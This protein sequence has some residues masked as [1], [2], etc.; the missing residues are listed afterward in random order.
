[1]EKTFAITVARQYGSGG[2][3][4]GTR[5]A[6]L[7][8]V[9]AY[10]KEL[11]T[12]A[13]QKS[14]VSSEVLG[15]ADERAT[16]SLLYTLALGSSFYTPTA[17]HMNVPIND[18]LFLVQSE[19]IRETAAMESCV[20]I[21]RCADY[22]LRA[23]ENKLRVFVYAQNADRYARLM[24]RNPDKCKNEREAR[25]L[26]QRTDKRRINYYN[27]YTGRKWGSMENYDLMIDSS[28]FGIEGTAQIIADLARKKFMS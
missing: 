8:G 14:G 26:A 23:H 12:M 24:Q 18:Q 17:A 1:M 9:K 16:S 2:R 3:E 19:I 13:A 27:Y 15:D 5:V 25:D 28:L 11:I 7:L 4:I 22:V 10:D 6:E 20:F 21:G